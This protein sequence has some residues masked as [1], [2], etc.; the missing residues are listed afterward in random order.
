VI[1]LAAASVPPPPT[2]QRA[3]LGWQL[4]PVAVVLLLCAAVLYLYGVRRVLDA[5]RGWP[6]GRTTA[7]LAGLI[8]VAVATMSGL[9]AYDDVLFSVHMAQHMLLTMVAPLLIVLAAPVTLLL[10]AAG[11]RG[12]RATVRLLH[13]PPLVVLAHPAVAWV[14]FVASPFVLYFTGL[15]ELSLRH[16][17]LHELVHVHFLAVGTLFL[18]PLVGVDP[19]PRRFPDAARMLYAVLTLPFH[20]FLGVAIMGSSTLLAGDYYRT[21]GRSWGATPIEEQNA[22]GGLL[23]AAGDLVGLVLVALVLRQWMRHEVHAAAREDRRI[24]RAAG[25]AERTAAGPRPDLP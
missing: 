19:V 25:A 16:R 4:E 22:G 24:D 5:G 9:S 21:L 20:A 2:W 14:L 7:F 6:P 1:P 23:W 12:R 10:G 15:Y 18:W 17:V 13:S 3:L 8:V 11:P